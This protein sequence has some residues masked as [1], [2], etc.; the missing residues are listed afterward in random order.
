[1]AASSTVY[2]T[3]AAPRLD[4]ILAFR[5][6]VADPDRLRRFYVEA[7]GFKSAAPKTISGDEMALLTVAGSGQRLPLSLGD[8]RIDL[9]RFS[10]P[11]RPYPDG[12]NA[13]DLIFQHC[14]IVVTDIQASYK[15]ALDFGALAISTG[16]P[17]RLPRSAGGVIA[18]K[19]RDPEGHPLEFLQFPPTAHVSWVQLARQR[20]GALG[21]D[22]SAI[23]VADTGASIRFYEALGL[24]LGRGSLNEGETQ[25]ALDGLSRPR[26]DV[27]PLLPL[28]PTPHLELLGYLAP[29]GRPSNALKPNDIAA[30]RIV[31]AADRSVLLRDLDGHLQQLERRL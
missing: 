16:A 8:Q 25:A 15:R 2:P 1:M 4:R 20:S 23:S 11:G 3:T 28:G 19:F 18:A 14:A 31:W 22:H 24:G 9:D 30:T 7:L 13:A 12:S 27:A 29:R 21:I 26:V 6:S 5:L 17:V 10:K